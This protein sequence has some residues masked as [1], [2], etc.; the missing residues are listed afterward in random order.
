MRSARTENRLKFPSLAV[1]SKFRKQQ[2]RLTFQMF[3]Y[4][5]YLA[6]DHLK[7]DSFVIAIHPKQR[8]S[9]KYFWFHKNLKQNC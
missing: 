3:K 2:G 7:A 6:H 4:A 1:S 5:Y 9:I 8:F